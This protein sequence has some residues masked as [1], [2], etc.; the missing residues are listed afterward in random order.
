MGIFWFG[1]LNSLP[2]PVDKPSDV[3]YRL[4]TS[5]WYR[6]FHFGAKRYFAPALFAIYFVYLGIAVANHALYVIQDD[7]GL[8][9]HDVTDAK[10][11]AR[12]ETFKIKIGDIEQLP[13]FRTSELCQNMHVRLEHGGKY[14]IKFKMTSP[15]MD[16]NIEASRGFYTGD[17]PAFWQRVIMAAGLPIR[18]ELIRPWFR[19]VAR[20]GSAGGEETFLDPD[21]DPTAT[22]I[23]EVILA[24]RDGQ[25]FL[26][27]NDAVLGIPGLYGYFYKDNKGTAD[28]TITRKR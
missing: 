4:R 11:L 12:D 28:V 15:F 3:I 20:I 1:S 8:V 10:N 6:A 5:D 25:L 24:T 19:V 2:T 13:V 7:A 18:R 27:V 14:L 23:E 16:G 22:P 9:C 21:P 26:F 17:P